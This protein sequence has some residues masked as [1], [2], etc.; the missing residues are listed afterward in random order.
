MS[1][2]RIGIDAPDCRPIN[3]AV[4][5]KKTQKKSREPNFYTPIPLNATNTP[6]YDNCKLDT[7][8]VSS[9]VVQNTPSTST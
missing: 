2:C 9:V 7:R 4:M 5:S 1:P 3:V 8:S 6:F